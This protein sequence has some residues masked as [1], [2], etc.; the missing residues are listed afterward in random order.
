MRPSHLVPIVG[1]TFGLMVLAPLARGGG[2]PDTKQPLKQPTDKMAT[3]A[4]VKHPLPVNL[5][6]TRVVMFSAGVAYFHREGDVT[7]DGRLDLRFDEG[8]VNDLL[9]SLVLTDK[10][11]GK[12]RA[13]TYD[14]RMPLDFTLK[15]FAVD[16]TE[17]PTMGQLMHQVRGEKVEVADKTGVVTVGQIVSVERPAVPATGPDPGEILNLLTE[18]GLQTVELKQ[19]KK[20]KLVRPELQAEFK[21]ALE[22]LATARGDN[23]KAVSVVFSGNG[24]R[25]VAV[26]YVN[27]APLWK[28]SYRLSVDDKGATRIQGWA[29]IENTT[30]EDWT[31][32]KVGLVA[33]RPMS[34]QMD[35]YDPLFVPRPMVEPDL[36]AS[37]RPPMYQGGLNP[38]AN[39]G[40]AMGNASGNPLS[41]GG[42]FGGAGQQLGGFGGNQ[43]GNQ[44]NL[45]AGG[46][47]TG[48][49]GGQIGN[50]GGQFGLQGGFAG[51]YGM[52]PPRVPRPN[53]R[54]LYGD[55][56]TYTEYVNRLRGNAAP[57]E[58]DRPTV[59]TVKDPLDKQAGALAVADGALGD[60]FEYTIDEPITLAKQKS[61]L[62]P[63]V[64][65]AVEGSRVSIFNANTLAK[66]PLLGLK[67]VNKTKLHLAQGPVTVFDGGTF[68]GDARLPD[69]KPGETRL[70]SY[71]IDLGTE[72]VAE[73]S[74]TKR[75]LLSV[76]VADGKL[77][78]RAG[79]KR[80]TT[81]LIR[82]R[83][84]QD[85]TVIVEHPKNSAWELVT[86]TKADDQTRSF[87]RFD[88]VVKTG[89][90]VTLEV[91]EE[92]P[93]VDVHGLTETTRDALLRY[94]SLKEA[95]PAVREV[96]KKLIE[97]R[98]KVDEA[99]KGI[100]EEQESLKEIADDQERIRKN[101]E[102]TPKE[103]EAF[104]RYLKK[105]D[106]QETEIEKRR[107]RVKELKAE[108]TKHEKALRDFA[109]AA[110]AE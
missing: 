66:H 80:V 81:Y 63:L 44:G 46:G 75:T 95:K 89:A 47:I 69:I 92:S 14:N 1:L 64:N 11:G 101:I 91:T 37:L 99:Q 73:P 85:R 56:L 60:M 93:A 51:N 40:M 71:A 35:L 76:T 57:V 54:T 48:I 15:G 30:D 94:A 41:F 23:K 61:A 53:I 110:K 97:L 107:A 12:V 5:P 72:V 98:E 20:I 77:V 49:Q 50:L 31:N 68:A 38:T 96:F 55:R 86:P 84:P 108:L 24:K 82:N 42:G 13:V 32:V 104:K 45:G 8:D 29:T 83:N 65:E 34:F 18:D 105:F 90:L 10:D 78:M 100:T 43:L 67:L 59:A 52:Y 4:N 19:L 106:D 21:K 27:E 7:G 33:G 22:M 25:K 3:G 62:V 39:M 58:S 6:I 36:F 109:S 79:L 2:Q 9:K 102:R 16:V 88:S 70:V 26:G 74:E 28:P 103:S 87:Y 17:N